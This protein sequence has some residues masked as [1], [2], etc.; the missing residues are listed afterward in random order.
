MVDTA[1]TD[2]SMELVGG[3]AKPR[4]R[5][6]AGITWHRI[7]VWTGRLLLPGVLAILWQFLASTKVLNPVFTSEPGTILDQAFHDLTLSQTYSALGVTLYETLL[8]F[9]I[10]AILGIVVGM[11]MGRYSVVREILQPYVT[12]LNSLPRIA[13][14]PLFIIWFGLGSPSKIALSVSLVFFVLLSATIGG[15]STV[16]ADIL[17]LA[18]VLGFREQLVQAKVVLRWALPAIFSGLELGLVTSL[19]GAVTGEMLGAKS[20]VGVLLNGY[21]NLFETGQMMALLLILAIVASFMA[22][23]MR[24]IARGLS[25]NEQ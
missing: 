1:F 18:R 24:R 13:L 7:V 20:G 5:K 6:T 2:Q 22:V 12:A 3:M 25:W 10:G 11:V 19:L 17:R 9:G 8:G 23:I 14:A 16:D 21:A 4:A 15:I